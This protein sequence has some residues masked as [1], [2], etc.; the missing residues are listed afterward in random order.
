MAHRPRA[1]RSRPLLN[2]PRSHFNMSPWVS[3][4]KAIPTLSPPGAAI[5]V[6]ALRLQQHQGHPVP[7]TGVVTHLYA[8]SLCLACLPP[9]LQYLRRLCSDLPPLRALPRHPLYS[10]RDPPRCKSPSLYHFSRCWLS[11]HWTPCS[12]LLSSWITGSLRHRVLFL[13][14]S[15]TPSP[16]AQHKAGSLHMVLMSSQGKEVPPWALLGSKAVLL[17][18]LPKF[19]S[20]QN[21]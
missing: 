7:Q 21:I 3:G 17:K 4:P 12:H 10:L 14:V 6:P 1:T 2:S 16:R 9:C 8:L 5:P 13:L 18:L 19:L 20:P 15:P 11:R